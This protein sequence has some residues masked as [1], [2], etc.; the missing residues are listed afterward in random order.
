[1]PPSKR[2]RANK[3]SSP[4]SSGPSTPKKQKFDEN[5]SS[6][7]PDSSPSS[8][9]KNNQPRL[10]A[11]KSDATKP[12]WQDDSRPIILHGD[13]A[14][15]DLWMAGYLGYN[16]K[17][18]LR[19][20]ALSPLVLP[21]AVEQNVFSWKPTEVPAAITMLSESWKFGHG[22][23]DLD[24]KAF[25]VASDVYKEYLLKR[26]EGGKVNPKLVPNEKRVEALAR[27]LITVD[28]ELEPLDGELGLNVDKFRDYYKNHRPEVEERIRSIHEMPYFGLPD[29]PLD[30]LRA[31]KLGPLEF[32]GRKDH[33][34]EKWVRILTLLRYASGRVTKSK[35]VRAGCIGSSLGQS[36]TQRNKLSEEARRQLI[37]IAGA[38]WLGFGEDWV[39]Q[40]LDPS[41]MPVWMR[42]EAMAIDKTRKIQGKDPN[43][44]ERLSIKFEAVW[45]EDFPGDNPGLGPR[46][47]KFWADA[48]L[49]DQFGIPAHVKHPDLAV[50][51]KRPEL[52]DPRDF[53]DYPHWRDNLRAG[54][55]SLLG[56]ST[57]SRFG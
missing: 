9:R 52:R 30:R 15:D 28:E 13:K 55:F 27:I 43:E 46:C 38:K 23:V 4:N 3:N 45:L 26:K 36:E 19:N 25:N 51:G 17:Y 31:P 12:T 6:P 33:V 8:K 40:T 5:N 35:Y 16:T 29:I 39:N 20:L 48:G 49:R 1:M 7:T 47:R 50:R 24:L 14:H 34:C 44:P 42:P 22:D 53:S 10:T 56:S 21:W 41:V 2:T 57:L 37:D 18:L 32:N 11:T 54:L